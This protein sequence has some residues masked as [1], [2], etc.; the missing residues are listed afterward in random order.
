MTK[1]STLVQLSKAF[2]TEVNVGRDFQYQLTERDQKI[3]GYLP[4]ASSRKIFR[5]ILETLPASTDRKAHLITALYGT[6]KS[7]L[8][9][10]LGHLLGNNRPAVLDAFRQTI[11][12][13]DDF[14][15]DK[16]GQTLDNYVGDGTR[17]LI[18]IPNTSDSDFTHA[19]VQGLNEALLKEGIDYVPATNY[20]RAAETLTNWKNQQSSLYSLF[21]KRLQSQSPDEFI[22][23]LNNTDESAYR[24]FKQH[25]REV[26]SS[27]FSE[28]H[29]D[30]AYT[31]YAETAKHV[32]DKGYRG[33]VILCDEFGTMLSNLIN[34]PEGRGLAVQNFIEDIKRPGT[35][36]NILFVA[37][38]HQDPATLRK[39]QQQDVK[40]V[41]GRFKSHLLEVTESEAEEILGMVFLHP[42]PAGFAALPLYD[43]LADAWLRTRKYNLYP[44]KPESWIT[45]K[46]LRNL[47]P[48]HPLSAYLLPLLSGEFAQSTRSMF[49]FLSPDETKAGALEPFLEATEIQTAD[50]QLNLFT[51]DR[52][53][54]FFEQNLAEAKKDS[55]VNLVDSYRTALHKLNDAPETKQLYGN[56]LLLSVIGGKVQPKKDILF[57]AMNWPTTK[58]TDFDNL[59]DDL[60]TGESL[61]RNPTTE[62]YEFPML[63][64]RSVSKIVQE[65]K[66]RLAGLSLTDCAVIW[67]RLEPRLNIEL[68]DQEEEFGANRYVR[69]VVAQ[70]IVD[71]NGPVEEL[72]KYYWGLSDNY[73]GNGLLFYLLAPTEAERRPMVDALQYS[74]PAQPYTFYAVPKDGAMFE[75]VQTRTIDYCAL[76]ATLSREEVRA[77]PN[78]QHNVREQVRMT[79]ASLK[80]AIKKVYEPS[81]WI[82]FY[83]PEPGPQEF[84]SPTGFQNWFNTKI[85]DLFTK[86]SVPVVRE[87]VLWFKDAEKPNRRKALDILWDADKDGLHLSSSGTNRSAQERILENFLRNLKLTKDGKTLNGTVF[88]ELKNPEP[89]TATGAI[90]RH[91]DKALVKGA[92]PI[93]PTEA[94][95]S[96][97]QK[98]F[99]LSRPL[100]LFMLTAYARANRDELVVSDAKRNL[101]QSLSIDLFETL[102]RKPQDYRLRRIDMSGPQKRYLNRLRELFTEQTARSFAEVGKQMV[103]WVNFLTPLQRVLIQQSNAVQVTF[104]E[105]LYLF[106][107]RMSKSGAN[108]E[109]E[110]KEFLLDTL[111]ASLL[112]LTQEQFE[113][114]IDNGVRIVDLI[115]QFKEF[116]IRKEREFRLETLAL[117]AKQVFG[118]TLV[119]K[120]DIRKITEDWFRQLGDGKK[121][122]VHE[123]PKLNDWIGI[124]RNGPGRKDLLEVYLSDLTE[125]PDKDW[126][127]NLMVC[128]A[129]YINEFKAYR[130]TI[131]EYTKGPIPTYRTIARA[132]FEVSETECPDEVTFSTLFANWYARLSNQV[133]SHLFDDKAVHSFLDTVNSSLSTRQRFLVV[134]PT[135]WRDVEK[136]P[137]YLPAE[138]EDWSESQTRA[139]ASEYQRC[140]QLINDWKPAVSEA[141]YFGKVGDVFGLSNTETIDALKQGLINQWMP[142]LPE[143]TRTKSWSAMNTIEAQFMTHLT[144][145]DFY[146]FMTQTLSKQYGLPTL[147]TMD[148]A[149]LLVMERKLESIRTRIETYRRPINEVIG[150]LEKKPHDTVAEYQNTLYA[151]LRDTEAF[152]NK[153]DKDATLLLGD[154]P[155]LL[156]REVRQNTGFDVIVPTLAGQFGLPEDHHVWS[157]EEQLTFVRSTKEQIAALKA[158]R[159]PEDRKM[160]DAKAELSKVLLKTRQDYGLSASQMQKIVNDILGEQS[161]NGHV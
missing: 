144:G 31:V 80:T 103:G 130:K 149:T 82:W 73:V 11:T 72:T 152:E 61:E 141:E 142:G 102:M 148:D 27:E 62:V 127:G 47:Y 115:R 34:S 107:D 55:I 44:D 22:R 81:E 5:E 18:V 25:F 26:I 121:R 136:L 101:A 63:G 41:V 68:T 146:D 40:K 110:A 106:T 155:R 65:E 13:K 20:R 99:G 8:L 79:E 129:Q 119:N 122:A 53:L 46:V 96:L 133:K 86:G 38:S 37:A 128:Q 120:E 36:A 134:I 1:L 39:D 160:A 50:G 154:I 7:Y 140:Y 108:Q 43:Y 114:D 95:A 118:E 32:A 92:A 15:N 126:T 14:Y 42:D 2:S 67:Q 59:L 143:R 12:G 150:I 157:R 161:P 16:L 28:G 4:N 125:N 132:V 54:K 9:L 158:W 156:L 56:L 90:F 131:E 123:Q 93:D 66:K 58:R 138:W 135:R 33:I 105:S 24:Q 112:H 117:M 3:D 10:M 48:L 85:N 74:S 137:S 51:P 21:T 78:Q 139:V 104:Y 100:T 69:P 87:S 23:L 77:N 76:E 91:F 52:L 70:R 88:G 159:F 151:A 83:A 98:P 124:I 97:L 64:G 153:A 49:N 30:D 60:V 111:P 19:L 116:P 45:E 84:K 109:K 6:G 145:S 17:Y 89:G 29:A 75:T 35:G 94:L 71:M 147:Q 57:W 113:D